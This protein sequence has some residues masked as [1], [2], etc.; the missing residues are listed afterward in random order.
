[1]TKKTQEQYDII[2]K[3]M[4]DGNWYK[5]VDLVEELGVKKTRTKELLRALVKVDL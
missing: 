2:L 4:D 5:T 3:F 1:M